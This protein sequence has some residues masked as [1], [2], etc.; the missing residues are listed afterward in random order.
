MA[1]CQQSLNKV[2]QWLQKLAENSTAWLHF[3]QKS[4]H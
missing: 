2:P 3:K 4:R 1:R